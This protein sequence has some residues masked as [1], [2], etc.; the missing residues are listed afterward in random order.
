M[1]LRWASWKHSNNCLPK[2]FVLQVM[3]QSCLSFFPGFHSTDDEEDQDSLP[4]FLDHVDEL[5]ARKDDLATTQQEV[6]DLLT[7]KC[8]EVGSNLAMCM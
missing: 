8:T 5:H 2:I 1:G 6:F 7:A 4:A 3:L